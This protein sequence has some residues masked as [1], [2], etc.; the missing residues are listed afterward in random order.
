MSH[1]TEAMMPFFQN[2]SMPW[3]LDDTSLP[4]LA[5]SGSGVGS[6]VGSLTA[7]AVSIGRSLATSPSTTQS[8][9][10]RKSSFKAAARTIR[11]VSVTTM[12]AA[13]RSPQHH[14]RVASFKSAKAALM[15]KSS[16]SESVCTTSSQD[17]TSISMPPLESD[18]HVA[19]VFQISTDGSND[20]SS[21]YEDSFPSEDDD[22]EDSKVEVA[23]S[24]EVEVDT[25]G[26]TKEETEWA[27]QALKLRR[28]KGRIDST[29]TNE[30][31]F[32][33]TILNQNM[34][35]T[36]EGNAI[37]RRI[38]ADET[39][40]VL[41]RQ[42]SEDASSS[43]T[44]DP[45]PILTIE[46]PSP[47]PS[48][49]SP[50]FSGSKSN[51]ESDS[52][53]TTASNSLFVPISSSCDHDTNLGNPTMTEGRRRR[54]GV[55]KRR[56]GHSFHS[57][58]ERAWRS[59]SDSRSSSEPPLVMP[60]VL[61]P[62]SNMTLTESNTS[63]HVKSFHRYIDTTSKTTGGGGSRHASGESNTTGCSPKG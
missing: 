1:L 40:P 59:R 39:E 58:R 49:V 44:L 31:T 19:A 6:L 61:L 20:E 47:M 41:R 38:A 11:S 8:W 30:V 53:V 15:R 16:E 43:A 34:T 10:T 57:V 24:N 12:A 21:Q 60:Q 18:D 62:A 32:I 5:R 55:A 28:D 9:L 22:D 26:K 45:P 42:T 54:C 14:H 25:K 51:Q 56:H 35:L 4:P 46:P 27:I 37:R 2:L 23:I 33:N 13:V 29:S 7:A 52:E 48:C 50:G 36:D 17:A 3:S 63:L